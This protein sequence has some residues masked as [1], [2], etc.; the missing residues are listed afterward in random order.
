MSHSLS[1]TLAFACGILYVC[2]IAVCPLFSGVSCLSLL[3]LG[4]MPNLAGSKRALEWHLPISSKWQAV[5]KPLLAHSRLCP[6]KPAGKSKPIPSELSTMLFYQALRWIT[7]LRVSSEESGFG[8]RP[9]RHS[10]GGCLGSLSLESNSWE[11][12][13]K[14]V[15]KTNFRAESAFRVKTFFCLIPVSCLRISFKN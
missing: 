2:G 1:A 6:V 10:S 3:I 13:Q 8:F 4:L 15:W 14:L 7:G 11:W 5:M 9:Q 12:P